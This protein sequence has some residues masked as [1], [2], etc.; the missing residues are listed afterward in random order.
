[1]EKIIDDRSYIL[2]RRNFLAKSS[3]GIGTAALSSLLGINLF[4]K[5]KIQWSYRKL[6]FCPKGEKSYLFIPKW[7]T[8]PA[9][10]I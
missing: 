5:S 6:T 9:R 8:F 2:N 4:K 3:I 1:M 7:R 10:F